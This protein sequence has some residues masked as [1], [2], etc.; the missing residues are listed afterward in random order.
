MSCQCTSKTTNSK[1]QKNK[2]EARGAWRMLPHPSAPPSAAATT[3]PLHRVVSPSTCQ[4]RA[5][6]N[7]CTVGAST[8]RRVWLLPWCR[9]FGEIAIVETDSRVPLNQRA[10]VPPS[11]LCRLRD[12][13][14]HD[15]RDSTVSEKT[16]S[17]H[18]HMCPL[19]GTVA[20]LVRKV[21]GPAA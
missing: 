17:P 1:R 11:R 10:M 4:P 7:A 12:F 15:F 18:M 3:R 5:R 14:D 20:S 16:T 2:R 19:S 9:H 8:S 13:R 6:Y 21:G